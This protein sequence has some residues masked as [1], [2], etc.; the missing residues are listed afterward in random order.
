MSVNNQ[1]NI[2]NNITPVNEEEYDIN[3]EYDTDVW[4][5]PEAA[6]IRT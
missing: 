1:D 5:A 4:T 3:D 6:S 2:V